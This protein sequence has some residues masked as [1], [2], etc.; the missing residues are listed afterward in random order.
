MGVY[1]KGIIM[2][3]DLQEEDEYCNRKFYFRTVFRELTPKWEIG[4]LKAYWY[5]TQSEYDK[6]I[7][8]YLDKLELLRTVK[9]DNKPYCI[10]REFYQDVE[11]AKRRRNF[12]GAQQKETKKRK[13]SYRYL[14]SGY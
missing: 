2:N 6:L 3:Q 14:K 11:E 9:Q 1:T 7:I 13:E 12:N 10:D 5:G 8:P 4:E